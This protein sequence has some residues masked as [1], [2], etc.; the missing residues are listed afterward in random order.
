M[1][2]RANDHPVN[3]H[4]VIVAPG[5]TTRQEISCLRASCHNWA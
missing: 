3:D 1:E 5:H 2:F 4:M